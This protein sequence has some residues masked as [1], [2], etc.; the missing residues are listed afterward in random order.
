[1]GDLWP[2]QS[3]FEEELRLAIDGGGLVVHYQ[4]ILAS[5]DGRP[6]SVEALVR[7]QHATHGLIAPGQFI[8]RA[9]ECGLIIAFGEWVL[10]RACIDARRWPNLRIAV[11]V[12]PMQFLHEGF[13]A[14]VARIVRETGFEP[15]RLELELTE[16]IL[17]AD[18]KRAQE[19]ITTLR[20][21]GIRMALDDFGTGYSSLSYLHR[22]VFDKIK[23][24]RSFLEPNTQEGA[25]ILRAMIG[26]GRALGM[27]V[28]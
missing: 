13:V 4:P 24:D 22:F 11:N 15:E 5:D 21:L 3:V 27:T 25:T 1:M 19:A 14:S 16:G 28:T 23:I 8:G 17:I 12:S 6:V 2:N 7:W 10:R 9:E 26:L 18:A 20:A